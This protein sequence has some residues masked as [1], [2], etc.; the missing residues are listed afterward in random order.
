MNRKR[1]N[2]YFS[3]KFNWVSLSHHCLSLCNTR[4]P[5]RKCKNWR[6]L[7]RSTC[8][9]LMH[10]N[11]ARFLT[12]VPQHIFESMPS[13]VMTRMSPTWSLGRPRVARLICKTD[14]TNGIERIV[15]VEFW[16]WPSP[17]QERRLH[18][19]KWHQREP[20]SQQQ[21]I[22]YTFSQQH[23]FSFESDRRRNQVQ[24]RICQCQV[25]KTWWR[26]YVLVRRWPLWD[27]DLMI[28]NPIN[29]LL[30]DLS[31]TIYSPECCCIWSYR[32]SQFTLPT[33]VSP[34]LNATLLITKCM[35]SFPLR[36]TSITSLPFN[37]PWSHGCYKQCKWH[38][39]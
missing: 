25:T 6:F 12:C 33:T 5:T 38:Y 31:S 37:W 23:Q 36:C 2:T 39:E 17:P 13:M 8:N 20:V 3:T 18:Y 27:V 1:N 16:N 30:D 21:S 22:D 29:V 10:C 11:W 4:F 9:N 26:N 19:L 32:R 7:V 35:A 28:N 24:C 14:M 34:T 15:H